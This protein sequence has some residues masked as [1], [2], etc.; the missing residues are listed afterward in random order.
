[1]RQLNRHRRRTND[2]QTTWRTAQLEGGAWCE[3]VDCLNARNRWLGHV[4]PCR[5]QN[6]P[7]RYFMVAN[8]HGVLV[9]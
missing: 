8:R 7:R 5:D 6:M 9:A 1:M 3:P 2:Q 4:C